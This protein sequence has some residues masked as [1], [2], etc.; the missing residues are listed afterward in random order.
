M[1]AIL[2][3][4]HKKSLIGKIIDETDEEDIARVIVTIMG[5][6]HAAR[7]H[8]LLILNDIVTKSSFDY[9]D[10][11]CKYIKETVELITK[12]VDP[13]II[14]EIIVNKYFTKTLNTKESLIYCL[15]GRGCLAIQQG[16]SPLVIKEILLSIVPDNERETIRWYIIQGENK[17]QELIDEKVKEIEK[18]RH[19]ERLIK[20]NQKDILEELVAELSGE[21][22]G[23]ELLEKQIEE[24]KKQKKTKKKRSKSIEEENKA[25]L[26][27]FEEELSKKEKE[28]K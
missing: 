19:N 1:K 12:T 15:V 16:L 18:E 8:G 2:K 17:S 13:K 27:D 24:N 20:L 3:D 23:F 21:N 28:A 6:S 4:I 7:N 22:S 25:F 26:A 11:T 10:N 5:L 14:K 9:K